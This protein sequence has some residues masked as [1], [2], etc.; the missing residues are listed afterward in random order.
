MDGGKMVR[1]NKLYNAKNKKIRGNEIR[2][3]KRRCEMMR[4]DMPGEKD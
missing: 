3:K 1:V 2:K 4:S